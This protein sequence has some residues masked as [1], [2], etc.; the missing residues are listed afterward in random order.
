[1]T[2]VMDSDRFLLRELTEADVTPR[3]LGWLQDNSTRKHIVSADESSDLASLREYVTSRIGRQDILFLGIFEKTSGLHVGN[4]K[5]EPVNS[6]L[7]YAVMGILIGDPTFRGKGVG[8]EVLICSAGWLKKY[9]NIHQILLG[10]SRDN[11]P[12]MRSYEK[13][14]FKVSTSPH[15]RQ[16]VPEQIIMAWNIP[17]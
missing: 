8:T 2:I 14:G 9:R 3:Y 17:D 7:G 15:L 12:A 1:M 4:I 16:S 13:A 10:V 5:Y 6:A 11:M